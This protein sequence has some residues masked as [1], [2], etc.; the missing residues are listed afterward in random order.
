M[1]GLF[2]GDKPKGPSPQ[3]QR[4]TMQGYWENY[5]KW[6]RDAGETRTKSTAAAKADMSAKGMQAGSDAWNKRIRDV[7]TKY[8]KDMAGITG[9]T[10]HSE[11]TSYYQKQGASSGLGMMEWY[12]KE[13]GGPA[14]ET[15]SPEDTSNEQARRAASGRQTAAA[16]DSLLSKDKKKGAGVW[17]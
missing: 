9:G 15:K 3:E 4:R 13:F 1:G 12:T 14:P 5:S 17:W 2:G 7:Q 11:L 8:D 10:H 6:V 16:G